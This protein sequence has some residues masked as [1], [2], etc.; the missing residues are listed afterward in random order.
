MFE[1]EREREGGR[2]GGMPFG[3]SSWKI[4]DLMLVLRFVSPEKQ[5]ASSSDGQRSPLRAFSTL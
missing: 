1:M 2:E 4:F 5:Y 3:K